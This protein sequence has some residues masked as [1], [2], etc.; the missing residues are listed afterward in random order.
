M[1]PDDFS[2]STDPS[3]IDVDL[4]HGFLIT[5]LAFN[6]QLGFVPVNDPGE[7]VVRRARRAS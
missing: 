4:V 2:I 5:S 1:V 3:R 6:G 7:L